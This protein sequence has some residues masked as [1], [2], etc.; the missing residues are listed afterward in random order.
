MAI[1]FS[2]KWHRPQLLPTDSENPPVHANSQEVAVQT[3]RIA[4]VILVNFLSEDDVPSNPYPLTDTEQTNDFNAQAL[5]T[6]QIIP[7][8]FGQQLPAPTSA[9]TPAAPP[10]P[11]PSTSSAPPPPP[12][13]PVMP[14]TITAATNPLHTPASIEFVRSMGLPEFL[15]GQN[16]QA[17]QA[18]VASPGLLNSFLDVTGNYDQ[19]KIMNL[20]QV[21]NQ[22]L[23][24]TNPI[25][26]SS[27]A[28]TVVPPVPP[29]MPPPPAPSTYS[30]FS[31][32][33]TQPATQYN[34]L[35]QASAYT[36]QA[37][38]TSTNNGYRGDQNNT[39]GNLHLSGYNPATPI[40]SIVAL[41][42]PYV[43][44]DEVVPK[45]GFMFLNTSDPEG[46]K[47]AREA[48]NG[49]M[50]GGSPLRINTALRRNK[51][52]SMTSTT[53]T[54]PI[55][56]PRNALGQID[57]DAVQD[58][59]GN[60]ATRN[61]F[62]AGYGA[63]TTEQDLRSVFG[64]Q[65]TVTGVVMKGTFSFVHTTDK[66]AAVLARQ[67]LTGTNVNG[68]NLRINFGKDIGGGTKKNSFMNTTNNYYGHTSF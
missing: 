52:P 48:L 25:A 17:L 31:S 57:F 1:I 36:Q 13:P 66:T 9:P 65:T 2:S 53:P 59:R 22:Q 5:T 39:D 42:A 20:I 26:L 23:Q 7:F 55:P 28:P 32:T 38:S 37:K 12:P 62:V 61:L 8:F 14:P 56:L 60:P 10:P 63:G 46:A 19:M 16:V 30:P 15:V 51:N 35:P 68:G 29:P 34:P 54:A 4:S 64:Q 18:I 50:I 67:A 27:Q 45:N 58:D 49:V 24:K 21:M 41:F 44:V 11:L 6:P 40:D 47:R 43:K 3:K 33:T